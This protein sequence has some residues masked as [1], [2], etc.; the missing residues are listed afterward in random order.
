MVG[1]GRSCG[2]AVDVGA[3]RGEAETPVAHDTSSGAE[4]FTPVDAFPKIVATTLSGNAESEIGD[5]LRS[6][7]DW[8]DWCLLID[9]GI[10]D[11][12]LRVAREIAG[13]KL[14]VRTF[15]WTHDFSAA[16]NFALAEAHGLGAD[17][18]LTLDTDERL[19]LQGLDIHKS[20]REATAHTLHVKHE[21][22]TYGKERFIRL[23]AR[24]AWRGPTH[25]AYTAG[26]ET[27]TL[28]LM[29][30]E[31]LGKDAAQYRRKAERDVAILTRHIAQS[32]D[33]PRWHYYLGDSL[34]GLK[35]H[36][37]AVTAFRACAE[38][39]GWDEESAWA[40]Y[41]AGES[42]LALGR[43]V[44]AIEACA[45][46]M[47][48]HAGLGELPWLAAYAAWR[49]DRPQQAVYWARLSIMLGHYMGSGAA[50][51]RIGFRHPPA[52][53][54]GPFDVLRFALRRTGDDAGA[55][56]AERLYDAAKHAREAEA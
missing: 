12:T 19:K 16:R 10:S 37:E 14:V 51:P 33:D 24:G 45:Q 47:S 38:L 34:A 53:W 36:E 17:W 54:E 29:A 39:R 31:E 23:P 25:E 20:L 5:A 56:E 41:R 3:G 48:R 42:L 13:S 7:V 27:A 32:P 43:P 40:L 30:F 21:A 28:P 4:G 44:D 2:G 55:D 1:T 9:T 46:G 18:A 35:R 15:P 11:D 8:V 49:A 26:G 6:V 50:V 52:L 22:G